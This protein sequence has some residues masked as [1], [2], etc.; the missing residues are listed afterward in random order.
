MHNSKNSYDLDRKFLRTDTHEENQTGITHVKFICRTFS[1]VQC[2]KHEE[3][4]K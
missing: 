1:D 3:I 2:I 4:A